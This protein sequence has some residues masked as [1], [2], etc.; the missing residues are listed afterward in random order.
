MSPFSPSFVI[1][2]DNRLN[3]RLKF[4]DYFCPSCPVFPGHLCSIRFVPLSTQRIVKATHSLIIKLRFQLEWRMWS[5]CNYYCFYINISKKKSKTTR[6]TRI[7]LDKK[8][9]LILMWSRVPLY[10]SIT[11]K[12]KNLNSRKEK[13]SFQRKT[14][15]RNIP[16]AKSSI[17][18][19]A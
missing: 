4:H 16:H 18:S 10:K 11:S 7:F 15:A 14:A 17:S 2:Q 13:K 5:K 1:C 8:S 6:C 3:M 12:K 19:N 9:K